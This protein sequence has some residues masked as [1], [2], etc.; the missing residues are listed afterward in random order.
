MTNREQLLVILMEECDE[1]S[2]RAS[3][4]LRFT[5]EEI[6]LGQELTNAERI[7]YEFSDL[8][9]VMQIMFREGM[10]PRVVD[11]DMVR[12]K[13]AKIEKWQEHSKAVGALTD[14]PLQRILD[15]YPDETFLR[16]DGYDSAVIGVTNG[17]LVYSVSKVLNILQKDMPYNEAREFFDFNI[18][19]A[20]VGEKTPLWVEDEA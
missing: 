6:Q 17:R 18:A 14:A 8:F 15:Q 3:K 19:G 1:V 2:Q 16:A 12:Q 13:Q 9:A 20:Y 5:L 10:I 11:M 4:A 7:V